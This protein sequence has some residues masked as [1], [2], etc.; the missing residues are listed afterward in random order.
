MVECPRAQLH[1]PV[2]AMV[3]PLLPE[4]GQEMGPFLALCV[5]TV[6][7]NLAPYKV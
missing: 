3:F 7:W 2:G 1:N 5:T 6:G 4:W